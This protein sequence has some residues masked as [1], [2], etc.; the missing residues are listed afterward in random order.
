MDARV[1]ATEHRKRETEL[2]IMSATD[3]DVALW[4]EVFGDEKEEIKAC[5]DAFSKCGACVMLK[6]NGITVSQFIATEVLLSGNRGVYIYA[7][8]TRPEFR[9]RGFMKELITLS[10]KHFLECGYQFFFLLPATERLYDTYKKMGFSLFIPAYASATVSGERDFCGEGKGNFSDFLKSNDIYDTKKLYELSS[11]MYPYEIFKLSVDAIASV[12]DINL[13]ID[14]DGDEGFLISCGDR[15]FLSSKKHESLI[16]TTGR[17]RA[18]I[19]PL[20]RG[21]SFDTAIS[22]E[23]IPR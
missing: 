20:M 5:L 19:M 15:V 3:A 12:A 13:F 18:Q 11:K 1:F 16:K 17:V 9:G 8:C 6:K 21:L 2:C 23:P 4:H 10:G 22:P 14:T 7:L